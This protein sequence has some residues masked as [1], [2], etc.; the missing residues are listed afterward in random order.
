MKTNFFALLFAVFA[1]QVI[2]TPSSDDLVKRLAC[3]DPDYYCGLH[4]AILIL[5]YAALVKQDNMSE[6]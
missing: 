1:A 4:A 3:R 5:V 2:A 6:K